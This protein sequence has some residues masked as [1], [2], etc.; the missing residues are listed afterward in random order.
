M[1]QPGDR[2]LMHT[3]GITEAQAANG[4]LFGTERLVALT[5]RHAADRLPAAETLRRLSHAV[6]EHQAG[7]PNDDATLLL[8]DW[9][10]EAAR[11]NVP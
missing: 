11:R 4:E 3:D 7:P 8:L 6:L 2:L 1:L 5:E 9:S 10:A